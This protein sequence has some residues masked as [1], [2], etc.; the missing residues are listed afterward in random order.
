MRI[1]SKIGCKSWGEFA[2]AR[3]ASKAGERIGGFRNERQR[4]FIV[5][6][7]RKHPYLPPMARRNLETRSP[8]EHS[9]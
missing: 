7:L 9:L 2:T 1:V 8:I 5:G 3:S 6:G 4:Q